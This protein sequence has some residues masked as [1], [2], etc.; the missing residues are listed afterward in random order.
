MMHGY[1]GSVGWGGWFAM[2]LVMV[3]FWG[4]LVAVVVALVRTG[5][6]GSS[7]AANDPTDARRILDERLARGEIQIEEYEALKRALAARSRT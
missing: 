6:R 3:V 5:G 4:L 2:V 1:Y 7:G